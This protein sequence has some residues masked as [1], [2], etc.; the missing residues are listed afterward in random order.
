MEFGFA[1]FAG[2]EGVERGPTTLARWSCGA[3]VVPVAGEG[4]GGV[5]ER[6]HGT[7][8]WVLASGALASQGLTE[9]G[10]L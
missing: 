1:G 5:V 10:M 3:V 4:G 6:G 2:F 7:G 9:H 8:S